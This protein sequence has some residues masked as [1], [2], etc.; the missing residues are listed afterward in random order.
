[1]AGKLSALRVRRASAGTHDDGRGLRLVV[2]ASGARAWVLRYQM[3]GRRR[4]MGLGPWPEITLERARELALEARTKIK[5]GIDPLAEK[6]RVTALTFKAAAEAN[7]E[8]KKAGWRNDKHAAQWTSTLETYA[9]PTLGN[10]DVRHVTTQE[11]LNVLKPI[12]SEKPETASRVRQRIEAVL[13]YASTIGARTGENPARWRGHL[14]N[15]LPKRSKVRA[16]RHH[17]ALDWRELPAFMTDLAERE[18]VAA[19]ALGFTILTAA[20]SNEVRELRWREIDLAAGVWTVPGERM[21]ADKEH[22]VPLT[23]AAISWLGEPGEADALV[24]PTTS[25]PRRKAAGSEAKTGADRRPPSRATSLSDAALSAVLERMDRTDITVHGFRSTFRDWAGETTAHPREVIE[26]ALAHRLKDKAEAAYARGDLFNKRRQLMQ[27]WADF[28][29][30][31]RAAASKAVPVPSAAE[32][33][34]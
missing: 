25:R 26:A 13:N 1:M 18:G 29:T 32:L 12:W 34:A 22:R 28:A 6:Q 9:Y 20:R 31:L 24:F 21:K 11:V 8:S 14:D 10:L 33:A 23:A 3:A 17:P 4:D 5:Q 19:K 15:L 16:V 30:G 2:K 7:I 27:D